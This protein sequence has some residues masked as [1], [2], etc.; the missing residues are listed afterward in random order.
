MIAHGS[1]EAATICDLV[2]EISC[3]SPS[4]N[5]NKMLKFLDWKLIAWVSWMNFFN[6]GANS[7]GP[8]N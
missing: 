2:S 4:V 1:E 5:I 7:V 8:L 3:K 6:K